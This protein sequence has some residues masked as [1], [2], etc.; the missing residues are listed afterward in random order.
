MANYFE[1]EEK[2]RSEFSKFLG[3]ELTSQR[4]NIF[5]KYKSF[6]LVNIERKV[7]GDIKVYI[8]TKGGN[9]P[10]AKRSIANEYVF[11]LQKNRKC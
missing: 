8:N 2:I 11:L 7:Y 1:I 10:S 3:I 9:I 4:V 5:G 6:D